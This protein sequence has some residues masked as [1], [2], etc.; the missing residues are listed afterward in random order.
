MLSIPMTTSFESTDFTDPRMIASFVIAGALV[1]S[2]AIVALMAMKPTRSSSPPLYVF[3]IIVAALAAVPASYSIMDANG[4]LTPSQVLSNNLEK[5]Y[6]ELDVQTAVKAT[7]GKAT[8]KLIDNDMIFE[9]AVKEDPETF[10]PVLYSLI[11]DAPIEL[12]K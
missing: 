3:G 6:P 10:E 8:A 11:T 12:G 4:L 5:A 2:I 7:N 1:L 9:V